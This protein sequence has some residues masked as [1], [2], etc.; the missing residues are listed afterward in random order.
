MSEIFRNDQKPSRSD[1]PIDSI[2]EPA[3]QLFKELCGQYEWWTPEARAKSRK[4]LAALLTFYDSDYGADISREM[5]AMYD[6]ALEDARTCRGEA[7]V[8]NFHRDVQRARQQADSEKEG[9]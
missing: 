7:E 6:E 1:N 5:A 9:V 4:I 3:F 8:E 2:E